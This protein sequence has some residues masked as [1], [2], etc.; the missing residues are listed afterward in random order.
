MLAGM[1]GWS[2]RRCI[3]SA[4]PPNWTV[5]CLRRRFVDYLYNSS[6]WVSSL[7]NR[8]PLMNMVLR[9]VLMHF[10]LCKQRVAGAMVAE[11]VDYEARRS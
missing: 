7:E 6:I 1:R 10:E 8:G 3:E 5:E 4:V 2:S 11:W 9:M